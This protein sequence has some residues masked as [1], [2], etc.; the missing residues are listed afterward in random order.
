MATASNLAVLW[1]RSTFKARVEAKLGHVHSLFVG[2]PRKTARSEAVA[3]F[4]EIAFWRRIL[5]LSL[6]KI[7]TLVLAKS[8]EL[9]LAKNLHLGFLPSQ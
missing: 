4:Y 8:F 2:R 1:E 3:I 5:H 7:C 6:L 9:F